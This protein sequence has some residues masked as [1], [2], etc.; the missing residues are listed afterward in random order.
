MLPAAHL[1][2]TTDKVISAGDRLL[3]R[4]NLTCMYLVHH[5]LESLYIAIAVAVAAV[6][7]VVGPTTDCH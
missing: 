2:N 5:E 6:D 4:E 7:K 1:K 3:W